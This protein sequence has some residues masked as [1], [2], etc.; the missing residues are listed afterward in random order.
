MTWLG[1]ALAAWLGSWFASSAEPVSEFAD[2]AMHAHGIGGMSA[3][4]EQPAAEIQP[5]PA[6]SGGGIVRVWRAIGKF[7]NAAMHVFSSGSMRASAKS[8]AKSGIATQGKSNVRADLVMGKAVLASA[9][10]AATSSAAMRPVASIR[11]GMH[12]SGSHSLAATA[13][14][15]R[16]LPVLAQDD[17]EDILALIMTLE[18]AA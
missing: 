7:L 18:L 4:T 12:V 1:N 3:T 17:E 2:A 13:Q 5:A 6:Y 16:R 8:A 14:A 9:N 10:I 15:T 11:A